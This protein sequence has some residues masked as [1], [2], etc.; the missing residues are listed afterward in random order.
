M[1]Q[2]R[3][4]VVLALWIFSCCPV[5]SLFNLIE[6]DISVDEQQEEISFSWDRNED[7]GSA[8]E[9]SR[10]VEGELTG[11]SWIPQATLPR[12]TTTWT[13][14]SITPGVVYEYRFF[15]PVDE[16]FPN[17]TAAY[18]SCG[19]R[20]PLVDTRGKVL[21]VVDETIASALGQELQRFEMDL[22]GDGWTV[23]RLNFGRD[24]T[25]TP[26]DLRAE[27][28]A[29][30]AAS[31]LASI[32]L[33]GHLPV[34]TSGLIRPDEHFLYQQP[35]DLF[36][37]DIDGVWTDTLATSEPDQHNFY[38]DDN[39]YDQNSIPGPNHRIEVPI[40]RVDFADMP[41]W[42]QG[43]TELLRLY[44]E[45]NHNFRHLR[46]TVPRRACFSTLAFDESPVEA[47]AVVG[48]LG[49]S[50]A[51]EVFSDQVER[52]EPFLWGI[53]GRHWNGELYPEFGIK[54][55]FTVNFLSGKQVWHY[56]NNTMRA[57]L[58]MP[59][60]GLTC[61]WGV[62]PNWYFHHTGMGE[63]IGYSNFRTVNN[64]DNED[65]AKGFDYSPID[66]VSGLLDGMVHINL[67]GDP[68]LRIHPVAPA[69]NI[70]AER[71]INGV[72]LSWGASSD[73]AVVGY[74]L[75]FSQSAAGPFS[76]LTST[77]LNGLS[78]RHESASG[79]PRYYMVRSVKLESNQNGTYWNAG[80]GV[81]T[82]VGPGSSNDA[83]VA[84]NL[85]LGA[86][87]E[88][89][90]SL[91]ANASD[92]DGDSLSFTVASNATNGEVSGIA[93]NFI[94]TPN[95]GFEGTDSFQ[96]N[97]W[98]GLAESVGTVTI[99]VG[100]EVEEGGN[101]ESPG[102]SDWQNTVDWQGQDSSSAAD[103]DQNGLSNFWEF[104][105]GRDPVG[106]DGGLF[107]SM[108]EVR[109]SG[110]DYHEAQFWRRK[111]LPDLVVQVS[112]NGLLGWTTLVEDRVDVFL[113]VIDGDATIELVRVRV[114]IDENDK[115]QFLRL[116]IL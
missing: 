23:E 101:E 14:S 104:Y 91:T 39:H 49:S 109:D 81:F 52:S 13:D 29:R 54:S 97:V 21:L 60:Y 46:Y 26:E 78:Y 116:A 42:P 63:T 73:S 5:Y 95:P 113:D 45:K 92:S 51:F 74:H 36:Y 66:E 22:A 98:D 108:E 102:Y 32:L 62:R 72:D 71:D 100:E 61:F 88:T 83:P 17:P 33:F 114:R 57:M 10:R 3:F 20:A 50:D 11:L 19:I 37:A 84:N 4:L 79:S 111:H 34:V 8:I 67:M 30:Y 69:G 94:Y 9:I 103:P 65:A 107:S 41:A 105:L 31:P 99:E 28:Q 48:M 77:P 43:E 89:P 44:L 112:N 15:V 27:I 38:P 56:D 82:R 53:A 96:F 35:T 76:R 106:E 68:T 47:A 58:A 55:Q 115:S 25:A 1:F 64:N 86:S 87:L 90:L 12:S 40:G 75:Y 7:A 24:E 59:W 16:D 110:V 93:P 85:Q 80:Q 2:T 18:V 6:L 70:T